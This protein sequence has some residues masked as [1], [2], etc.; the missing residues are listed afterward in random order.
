VRQYWGRQGT[1]AFAESYQNQRRTCQEL[2]DSHI[3]P[4]IV[5]PLAQTIADK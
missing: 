3:I 2:V 5:K 4:A 1:K